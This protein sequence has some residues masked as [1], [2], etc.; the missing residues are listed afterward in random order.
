M[1]VYNTVT[2]N[3]LVSNVYQQL[4]EN[5]GITEFSPGSL[6]RTLTQAFAAYHTN[7]VGRYNDEKYTPL[8]SHATGAYLDLWGKIT[9]IPR[10]PATTA[11]TSAES[12]VIKFYTYAN[13]FGS[14]NSGQDIQ[15]YPGVAI[16]SDYDTD[17]KR[18][19]WILTGTANELKLDADAD[20]QYVPATAR[21]QGSSGNIDENTLINHDFTSYT[22]KSNNSLM[23]TNV[24]AVNSGS[25]RESDDSYRYRIINQLLAGATGNRIAIQLAALS[26]S[27]VSTVVFSPY[28]LGIG[29]SIMIVVGNTP[30]TP[31]SLVDKVQLAVNKVKSEGS[32]IVCQ[33]PL[34]TGV[35]LDFTLTYVNNNTLTTTQVTNLENQIISKLTSYI[36]T[37][38]LG[39]ILVVNEMVE[40][41]LSTSES[42]LDIGQP[43][44]PFNEIFIYKYSKANAQRI[45]KR[46]S[47]NYQTTWNEILMTEPSLSEAITIR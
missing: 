18:K 38:K 8:I 21:E 28:R 13:N 4:R 22:D 1:T 5:A 24:S 35:A 29:T 16:Y 11:S 41:V 17:G 26:I 3:E 10:L 42:I 9:N 12:N 45:R 6:T 2:N 44:K 14:I 47:G 32:I 31:Q 20:F 46:I 36:N 39:G 19:T 37:T 40:R 30:S 7:I 34:E 23:V 43:N 27:G 33:K 15:L 25:E